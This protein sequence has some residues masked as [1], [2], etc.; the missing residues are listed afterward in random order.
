VGCM[1]SGSLIAQRLP[2]DKV[3]GDPFPNL[4]AIS[5]LSSVIFVAALAC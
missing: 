3:T 2:R 4:E 1:Q 5:F